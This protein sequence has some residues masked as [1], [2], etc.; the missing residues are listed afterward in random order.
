[1]GTHLLIVIPLEQVAAA[2]KVVATFDPKGAGDTFAATLGAPSASA[3]G[4]SDGEIV[5]GPATHAW[6]SWQL[7]DPEQVEAFKAAKLP[8]AR[9]FD[10]ALT[11]PADVLAELNLWPATPAAAGETKSSPKKAKISN[12]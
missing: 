9:L 7:L 12:E 5:T 6:A 10:G 11:R 1:M 3:G 2:R 4:E 8:G